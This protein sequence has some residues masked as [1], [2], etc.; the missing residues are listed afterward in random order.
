M[1]TAPKI[2]GIFYRTIPAYDYNKTDADREM[3]QQ[4]CDEEGADLFISTYYTTPI[5]TPS[6]FIAYD[7]IPEVLGADFNEPM[8]REKHNAIRHASAYI[9]ISENFR[10]FPPNKLPSLIVGFLLSFHSIVKPT[11]I[12]LK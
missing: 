3:L 9:S 5:S 6:V 4:V 10:E 11:L 8:W 1:G 12:N 2:P 7:M